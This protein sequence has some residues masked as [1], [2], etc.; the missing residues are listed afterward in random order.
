M[1]RRRK[2]R[3]VALQLL[4]QLDVQ[5]EASP[6]PHLDEFWSRH[7]VDPEAREVRQPIAASELSVGELQVDYA[8]DP[9]GIDDTH[10][11]LSWK[12][13]SQVNNEQQT[14]YRVLVA[15]DPSRLTPGNADVWDSGQIATGD[16][17]GIPYGGPALRSAQRYVW[18]VQVW[19]AHGTP[20]AWSAAGFHDLAY[21]TTMRWMIPGVLFLVLG[22]EGAFGSFL[23]SLLGVRRR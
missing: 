7:P 21:G 22:A 20:S 17:V 16:S 13:H 5:G 9:L 2:A 23:L 1:G 3:E 8:A 14:A 12:L 6:E 19:D 4:Y 15:S 18:T 10:P 11:S